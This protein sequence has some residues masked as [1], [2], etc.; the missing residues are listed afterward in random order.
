MKDT[1]ANRIDQEHQ[2]RINEEARC[3]NELQKTNPLITRTEALKATYDLLRNGYRTV[4]LQ[5]LA[6]K[7]HGTEQPYPVAI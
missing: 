7:V 2:E 4:N 5:E 3:A 1:F 6:E